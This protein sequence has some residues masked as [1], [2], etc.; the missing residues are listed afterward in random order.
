MAQLAARRYA[1]AIFELALENGKL[2]DYTDQ[3]AFLH[4]L[5]EK[6]TALFKLMTHPDVDKE[7]KFTI[8]RKAFAK[9]AS[10]DILGLLQIIIKKNREKDMKDILATFLAMSKAHQNIV[11]AYVDAP[12]PLSEKEL[13]S[14]II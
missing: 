6:E 10:E 9:Q 14:V 1:K 12:R 2:D 11:T 7:E 8:L 13:L 5:F 4:A 3:L